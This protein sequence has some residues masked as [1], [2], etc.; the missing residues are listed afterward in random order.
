M[1]SWG[2]GYYRVYKS[3]GKEGGI[4]GKK[5]TCTATDLKMKIVF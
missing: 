1:V 4:D 3:L 5:T 2:K